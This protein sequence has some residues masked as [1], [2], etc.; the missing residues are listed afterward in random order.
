LTNRE[1][2]DKFISIKNDDS[3]D[4]YINKSGWYHN[5]DDLLSYYSIVYNP[6]MN[7]TEVY[8]SLNK[9]EYELYIFVG[10]KEKDFIIQKIK[11]NKINKYRVD[12]L[13]HYNDGIITNSHFQLLRALQLFILD[14]NID[15]FLCDANLF[16]NHV[17]S[18]RQNAET[19][20]LYYYLHLGLF[21]KNTINNWISDAY[22]YVN[23]FD[24][25]WN[26]EYGKL[27]IENHI[28]NKRFIIPEHFIFLKPKCSI[29]KMNI[30]E[31]LHLHGVNRT[32][33]TKFGNDNIKKIWILLEIIINDFE[34]K[35]KQNIIEYYYNRWLAKDIS[36]FEQ[37]TIELIKPKMRYRNYSIA[38]LHD[39]IGREDER[40]WKSSKMVLFS[41]KFEVFSEFETINLH[42]VFLEYL[43]VIFQFMLRDMENILREELNIPRIGEGWIAETE[44]FN[45]IQQYYPNEIVIHHGKPQ[46]LGK[47][48]LDIYFPMKNIAIEYQGEQHDEPVA[49]FGGEKSFIQQKNRD[50]RK[51]KKCTDN[52]CIL[53]YVRKGYDFNELTN[54]I[55]QY[56][57]T[58]ENN[59]YL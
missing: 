36:L 3:V 18:F 55:N 37:Y 28:S 35:H 48:H 14:K 33:I 47:Q 38:E 51:L 25:F 20:S 45:K 42:Q 17:V 49:F 40:Y 50:K 5:K 1:K 13:L 56:L 46:W 9:F 44:L 58:N 59:N 24:N 31:F 22:L 21:G 41:R 12:N 10:A 34:E 39:K 26:N 15:K 57:L 6:I 16:F 2:I 7:H 8:N 27:T 4:D 19:N 53:I 29:K 54:T 11:N 52:K 23:D 32:R 30:I 43:S